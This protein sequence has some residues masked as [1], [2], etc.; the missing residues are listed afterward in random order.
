[1][2]CG[3]TPFFSF[4][5]IG[6]QIEIATKNYEVT[7]GLQSTQELLSGPLVDSYQVLVFTEVRLM[8]D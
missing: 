8:C 3:N 1:M 6:N 5:N 2:G 4:R 7:T